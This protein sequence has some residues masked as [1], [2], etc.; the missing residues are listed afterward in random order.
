MTGMARDSQRPRSGLSTFGIAGLALLAT[1]APAFG[2]P[3]PRSVGDKV[4]ELVD[5]IVTAEVELEISMRRS[6]ILRMR[7]DVFRVAVADPTILDFVAFGSREMELIGKQTGSTTVTLWLGDEQNAELLSMLVSVVKDDAVDDMRRL[8]YG[9]LEQMI[10]EMFPDSRIQL[11]PVADKLIVRGQ[12]RDEEEAIQ[13]MSLIRKNGGTV[14]TLGNGGAGNLTAQGQASEPFPDASQLP[15]ATV[16]NMLEVPGEKQ[17]MLKVRIAELQRSALRELGADF[18]FDIKEFMLDSV[19]AG[20]GNL[21]ATG[22]FSEGGFEVVLNF[23]MTNGSAKILAEPNLVT[24]SGHPATFLAGGEYPVPTTV[25]VGGVGAVSTSFKEYGT[26]LTFTPTVLD[27]DRIRL[28]VVPRFSTVNPDISVGAAGINGFNTR[29]VSTTVDL[30]EGQVLAI[31]GLLQEQQRGDNAR[32]PYLGDIPGVGNLLAD[33]SISRD[34][35]ELLIVVSPELVHPLEPERAPTLL[36]GMEVTEPDDHEF[37]WYGYIE[38]DPN[39]HHRSTV[40]P[41]YRQRMMRAGAPFPGRSRQNSQNYYIYGQQ[42]Y[43][44]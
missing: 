29:A 27:K 43:S 21:M 42:G 14:Q 17:V 32:V 22:T 30:R 35:T 6:K 16:I 4:N 12:A 24:L 37:F 20:A 33:R 44:Q 18:N 13:I 1:I 7:Q 39:V 23:L 10:N 31:A 34:E 15:E 38:G 40:W 25:G 11:F 3:A 36:P 2:Q 9:E 41:L 19:L 26:V 28:F 8:E 5:E